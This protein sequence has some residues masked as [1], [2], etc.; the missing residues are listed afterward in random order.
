[1]KSRFSSSFFTGNRRR[2]QAACRG[3][4]I[5]VAANGLLQR[6]SIDSSYLFYQDADFWYLTGIDE[7]DVLLVI[8]GSDEYLMVPE[9]PAIREAFDGAVDSGPL[10]RRSGVQTVLYGREGWQRLGERLRKTKR[11]LTPAPH[12][13]TTRHGIYPNP[14]RAVMK[15][16]FK[17]Y[18]RELE[19]VDI[20]P[21][22]ARLRMIKQPAELRAMQAAIDITVDTLAEILKPARLRKYGH[23]YELEA[24]I[25]RGFRHSGAWGHSFEPIV[26]GGQRACTL[27]NVSNDSALKPGE[28]VVVDVGA[29]AEHYAADITRTVSL[30]KPTKRQRDV[31]QAV[32]E[33]QTYALD[34]LRPGI[35]LHDYEKKVRE[36]MGGKL[37]VLGLITINT[38][39]EVQKFYPHGTSH[40]IGLNVHDA[41]DYERPLE[42]GMVVSCEPGIYIR[43]EGIG[44]RIEDD[45]LITKTGNKVL[46]AKLPKS[47][48]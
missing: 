27:H 48:N 14:A 29:E 25:T 21:K 33:V 42:P 15:T 47:L 43:D 19:F 23:E 40:F 34:L 37:V 20:L 36:H 41:G 28:L 8:D 32:L 11:V 31:H 18:N 10:T 35:K 13:Y 4:L 24:D 26:A 45:V 1:M 5:V 17:A 2:L 38:P 30:G 9:R 3:G 39:Q 7:P 16:R 12:K 22:L 44:V 6:G 46:T